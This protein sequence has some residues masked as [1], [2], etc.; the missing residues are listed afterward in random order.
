VSDDLTGIK[1]NLRIV[2]S[3]VIVERDRA[4]AQIR[5][6]RRTSIILEKTLSNFY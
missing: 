1:R 3:L 2:G 4:C 6:G 5:L